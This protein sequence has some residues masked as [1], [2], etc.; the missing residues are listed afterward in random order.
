MIAVDAFE[1]LAR[2][3]EELH[4]VVVGEGPAA[5]RVR[6]LPP[7]IEARVHMLGRVPNRDL[8]SIEAA[9][10]LYVASATGGESFGL[11]LIEALAAGLP[12]V[13]S[14]I[15]GYDEVASDGVDSLLV[16]PSDAAALE[17][18][19]ARV[20][21]DPGLARKLSEGA[22][23]KAAG[24]D[25]GPIVDRLESVYEQAAGRMRS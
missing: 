24:F 8:P 9:C 13:A 7:D 11:V 19:I 2:E 23:E 21:D 10:N 12:V 25:W 4:L 22:R 15:P 1:R 17:T 16:P 18:A 6:R 3:R 14:D 5:E 20:L